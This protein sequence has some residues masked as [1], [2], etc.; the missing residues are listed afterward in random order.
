MNFPE[1]IV[2]LDKEAINNSFFN[3]MKLFKLGY[4][5]SIA[6]S[7]NYKDAGETPKE[8]ISKVLD[9]RIKLDTTSIIKF[10]STPKHSL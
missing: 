10:Q 6:H 4:N 7:N 5:V 9:S 2:Y 3:A 8:Y 1:I